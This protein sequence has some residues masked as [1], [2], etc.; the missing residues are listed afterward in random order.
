V[1]RITVRKGEDGKLCG[2]SQ[3]DKRAYARFRKALDELEIGDLLTFSTW[4]PRNPA[5]HKMHFSMIGGLF[6]AQEQFADPDDL[7]RWLYVGAG[8]CEIV[9]GPRG[10]MVALPKSVAY[11]KLDDAEFSELHRKVIEFL[12]S[13]HAQAFLW[14]HLRPAQR[15]DAIETMLT[16][17]E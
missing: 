9:P 13:E 3:A 1:S 4:F 12:R 14:P 6:D 2:F 15:A 11:D 7:R 17:Y 10:R 8:Y 16:G 5:F